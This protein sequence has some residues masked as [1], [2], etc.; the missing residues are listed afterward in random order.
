MELFVSFLQMC[1]YI[2]SLQR[3]SISAPAAVGVR[4]LILA[5][6]T[7]ATEAVLTYDPGILDKVL[8]GPSAFTHL[9]QDFWREEG[10]CLHILL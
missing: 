8:A 7:E 6:Y 10:L 5:F 2:L 3:E 1:K 4:S 9:C